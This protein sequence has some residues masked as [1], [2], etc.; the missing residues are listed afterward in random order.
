MYN[1]LSAKKKEA[2]F[3]SNAYQQFQYA[4]YAV[5]KPNLWDS[6]INMI[7]KYPGNIIY[8]IF[9]AAF[10][11]RYRLHLVKSMNST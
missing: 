8:Y 6:L 10:S 2:A 7:R 4:N 9:Q 11:L 5:I 1:V 3:F